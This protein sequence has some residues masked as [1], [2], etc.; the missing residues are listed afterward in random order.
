MG[1]PNAT[2]TLGTNNVMVTKGRMHQLQ[3]IEARGSIGSRIGMAMHTTLIK[4]LLSNFVDEPFLLKSGSKLGLVAK[5][6][7][8]SKTNGQYELA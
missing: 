2:K 4:K 5:W 7:C 1:P 6:K 3:G 8:P